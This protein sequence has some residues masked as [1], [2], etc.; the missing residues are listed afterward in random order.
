M[1]REV[2]VYDDALEP[3]ALST[4][5]STYL[6]TLK[7]NDQS[8]LW[9]YTDVSMCS[10]YSGAPISVL[11]LLA[12]LTRRR[13]KWRWWLAALGA[14][15]LACAAG[16]ALPLR[17]WLYDWVYPMRFFRHA[18]IFRYY[19]LFSVS[20]LALLGTR[21]I[22][23]AI[24]QKE[25]R[26][27]KYFLATSVLASICAVA[28]FLTVAAARESAEPSKYLS[29]NQALRTWLA[30]S[31][32][33]LG[34]CGVA[35]LGLISP[36]RLK[37]WFVPA[38]LL[39]VAGSD[40]FITG[41]VSQVTI[42]ST[43]PV[44]VS[45]WRELD[46]NHSAVLDLTRNG[47]WREESSCSSINTNEAKSEP[48]PPCPLNDQYITK[49]PVFDSYT[50]MKNGFHL[51]M[52]QNAKLRKMASGSGRIWFSKEMCQVAPTEESFSAF[53][54]RTEELAAAPLLIHTPES[55]LSHSSID[56]VSEIT[57]NQ[58]S[59]IKALPACEQIRVELDRYLPDELVFGVQCPA[60]GWLLV[61]DRWA[62]SWQAEVNGKQAVVYGGNFI[63]RAI[64]V[65]AG[66]NIVRFAYSPR[67]FPWLVIVSWGTMA[68][69][70]LWSL[71]VASAK[72]R[73]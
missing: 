55:L 25:D 10:V 4:F 63:F 13:D 21:D 66:P 59:R 35:Y 1:S 47:L 24:K 28:V 39:I 15:S 45:R 53:V 37:T 42:T 26:T 51:R 56:E 31:G 38:M 22:A 65:S 61:T 6:A 52:T 70:A 71:R 72:V 27:W 36:D 64:Q 8:H 16:Q 67:A 69:V 33:W 32:T 14:L 3:G 18:A 12:L 62:R 54:A 57:A 9:P 46:R 2:A 50:T 23:V 58:I 49:I 17:G 48:M 34:V 73:K 30:V 68:V 20:V 41:S 19:Y 11:A 29:I 5:A 40:A 43:D 60:D 44:A 7:L